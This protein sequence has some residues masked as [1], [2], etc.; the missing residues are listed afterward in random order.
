[1]FFIRKNDFSSNREFKFIN[2]PA[3][4]LVGGMISKKIMNDQ[5]NYIY[6]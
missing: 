6:K 5:K 1:M 4:M 3:E 2:K